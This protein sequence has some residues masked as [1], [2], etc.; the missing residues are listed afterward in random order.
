MGKPWNYRFL[1]NAAASVAVQTAAAPAE[2]S[3]DRFG[4]KLSLIAHA[5]ILVLL[6]IKG[7]V[8][9]GKPIAYVP[10]LRVDLVGLPDILKKDLNKLSKI[11]APPDIEKALKEADE[12]IK[13]EAEPK[14]TKEKS[15]AKAEDEIG[16][17]KKQAV[18]REKKLRS[19]LDRIKALN[20]IQ[21]EETPQKKVS[22]IVKGNLVSKGTSLSPDAKE[23][24]QSN[25]LD[26]LRDKLLENWELPV[27]LARQ[28]LDAQV[29]LFIDSRG[30]V[31]GLKFVKTSGN[32]KFDDE[33]R[34][35][36]AASQPLP[37]PPDGISE[38]IVSNGILVGFPL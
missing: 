27:W 22:A 31:K 23:S 28:K 8:F 37:A 35:T 33:V 18:A 6:I 11:P 9:P 4:L 3:D 21:E 38:D 26:I 30:R 17:K 32:G 13:E 16:L 1:R 14:A 19:A 34:H 7:L 15:P 36:I 2:T 24:M 29:L 25:Y 5:V 20:K 10:A 12:K